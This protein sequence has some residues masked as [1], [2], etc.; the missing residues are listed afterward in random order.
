[1]YVFCEFFVFVFLFVEE[2]FGVGEVFVF[3][4]VVVFFEVG[5]VCGVFFVGVGEGVVKV[6]VVFFGFFFGGEFFFVFEFFEFGFVCV[7]VFF[8]FGGVSVV[9]YE[10]E[11]GCD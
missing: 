11:D 2:G 1:M 10:F 7:D 9:G 6:D 4:V 5:V 3:V 8:E